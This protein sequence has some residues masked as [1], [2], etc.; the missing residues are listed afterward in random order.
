MLGVNNHASYIKMPV[1]P[2][3]QG[4]GLIPV[5]QGL[6][7]HRLD[8][9]LPPKQIDQIQMELFTSLFVL[10]SNFSFNPVPE[11]SY[12]LY[13]ENGKY[14]L[15]MVGPHEWHRPYSGQ[16]IGECVLQQDRTWTL[17][18]GEGIEDDEEFMF[19]I[20]NS[21]NELQCSLE[22]A[23]SIEDA[24]PVYEKSFS[25]Y[26][27]I[28]AFTLGKSLDISMQL[29]GIKGLSYRDAKGLLVSPKEELTR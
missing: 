21:R 14:K 25:F 19:E 23:D 3:P 12:W 7:R 22:N 2:N 27:R 24:L 10:Q 8:E 11:K 29:S 13:R 9:L 15:L 5:L 28:L 6:D 16:F 20:E 26:G 4:K 1:N 18:L 17:E